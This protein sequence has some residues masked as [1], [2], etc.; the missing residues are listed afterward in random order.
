MVRGE[1]LGT[2]TACLKIKKS[3]LNKCNKT[4]TQKNLTFQIFFPRK[5][6]KAGQS[7]V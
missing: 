7:M 3:L 1:K 4:K 6:K 2:S 5:Q